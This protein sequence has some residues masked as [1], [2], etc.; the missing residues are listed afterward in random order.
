MA[1]MCTACHMTKD[2]FVWFLT[3]TMS[4]GRKS[5]GTGIHCTFCVNNSKAQEMSCVVT[6]QCDK[7]VVTCLGFMAASLP[8]TLQEFLGGCHHGQ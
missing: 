4:Q 3:G 2:D 5:S 1:C 7:S 8:R 6:V